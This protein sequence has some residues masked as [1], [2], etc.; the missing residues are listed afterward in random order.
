MRVDTP[1]VNPGIL[2]A[3]I[4]HCYDLRSQKGDYQ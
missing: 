1:R 3:E 2:F 4:T